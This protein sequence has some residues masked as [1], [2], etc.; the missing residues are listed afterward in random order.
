LQEVAKR[1]NA[2]QFFDHRQIFGGNLRLN[3]NNGH[4][5]CSLSFAGTDTTSGH[6][7]TIFIRGRGRERIAIES[8]YQHHAENFMNVKEITEAMPLEEWQKWVSAANDNLDKWQM[9]PDEL[10]R[11]QLGLASA[12]Y[13]FLIPVIRKAE[14]VNE[15]DAGFFFLLA[16]CM[17]TLLTNSEAAAKLH[18]NGDYAPLPNAPFEDWLNALQG[19]PLED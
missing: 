7:L 5:K 18:F 10:L 14:F 9:P 12:C 19:I 16:D 15:D 1:D 11:M 2:P 17:A 6:G 13:R 8:A 4:G 3:I